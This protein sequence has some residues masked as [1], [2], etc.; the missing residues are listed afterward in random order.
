MS[1]AANEDGAILVEDASGHE[2]VGLCERASAIARKISTTAF[3]SIIFKRL[4]SRH[5]VPPLGKG[6]QGWYS[7]NLSTGCPRAYCCVEMM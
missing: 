2:I 1:G 3:R 7:D 4:I 5:D 6:I